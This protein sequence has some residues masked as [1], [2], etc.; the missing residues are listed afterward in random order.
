MLWQVVN[1]FFLFGFDQ[2]FFQ[3]RQVLRRF[4]P[5]QLQQVLVGV[6]MYPE[7]SD[8]LILVNRQQVVMTQVLSDDIT[9]H[10]SGQELFIFFQ[11]FE[12]TSVFL[13]QVTCEAASL[14]A[15]CRRT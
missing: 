15:E 12:A 13:W 4:T 2:R 1:E 6:V 3:C 5:D 11:L 7:V 14:H 9:F 8:S 10:L